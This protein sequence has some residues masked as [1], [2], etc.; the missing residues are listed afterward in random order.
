MPARTRDAHRVSFLCYR[1]LDVHL[2]D[3][4]VDRR[5]M[6][7]EPKP[8]DIGGLEVAGGSAEE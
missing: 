2:P 1:R 7:R 4:G 5:L 6:V 3:R 8:I